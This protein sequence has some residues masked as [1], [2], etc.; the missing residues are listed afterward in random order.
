[1]ISG[2]LFFFI[3]LVAFLTTAATFF[4]LAVGFLVDGF[5]ILG[6]CINLV[7]GVYSA[8][9]TCQASLIHI[10]SMKC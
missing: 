2:V 7:A 8:I 5:E 3:T 10:K 6:I 4:V 9:N 1:M